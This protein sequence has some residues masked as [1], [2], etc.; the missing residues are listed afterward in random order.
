MDCLLVC[1][2]VSGGICH[3][4]YC[5]ATALQRQCADVIVLTSSTG[6]YELSDLAHSHRVIR[7]LHLHGTGVS[8]VAQQ[9]L[10]LAELNRHMRLVKAVHFQWP[11]GPRTDRL[12]WNA[13]RRKGHRVVYTAH[14]IVPHEKENKREGHTD[15]LY[16][17]ADALIVHG[18]ALSDQLLETYPPAAG[19][20]HVLPLGNYNFVA[21][22]YNQWDRKRARSS[23]GLAESDR[24]VL[25][26]GYLRRYKG[27]DTLIQACGSLIR[28]SGRAGSNVRLIIA[29]DNSLGEWGAGGY[30]A[31]LDAEGLASRTQTVLTYIP[32][33]DVGRYFHA[34]DVVALPYRSGSQSALLQLAYA[35]RK[36]AVVTDVGS[37]GESVIDGVTGLVVAPEDPKSL[38]TALFS[39]LDDP[40]GA[41]QLGEA[42]RSYAE[43][44][45]SWDRIA[46]KTL[47][48]YG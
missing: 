5:L 13:C 2:Q 28:S 15:W 42:G 48:I 20:I 26:F 22:A 34:A 45:F 43:T 14:N 17:T 41:N 18:R 25:F 47:S 30:D 24:V 9:F 19:R 33:S 35:F 16:A 1:P 12:L 29:G 7:G 44:E 6:D 8:R 36:P 32:L 27:I 21:D 39:L 10:N 40:P 11:L 4:T 37:I 31:L 23:F 46:S 3:Y 38:A